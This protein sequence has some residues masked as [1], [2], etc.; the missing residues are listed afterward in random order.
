MYARG[1]WT[2]GKKSQAKHKAK[3]LRR[4]AHRKAK[5][6]RRRARRGAGVKG[7]TAAKRFDSR[8][9]AFED[10]FGSW[11]ALL[12]AGAWWL[13]NCVAHPLLGI[14]P[15]RA[16]VWLH[17]RTAAWLNL[18]PAPQPSPLPT[19]GRRWSWLVHNCVSHPLMGLAPLAWCLS[20]HEDTA[21]QMDVPG[22]V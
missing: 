14:A 10:R 5:R 12:H 1:S 21:E 18:G 7:D 17:D 20:W 6:D 16:T 11:G 4:A 9:Q 2:K 8:C 13:H 22:W 19:I 15:G 3:G